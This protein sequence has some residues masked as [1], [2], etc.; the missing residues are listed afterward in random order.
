MGKDTTYENE[1]F[2]LVSG[3]CVVDKKTDEYLGSVRN[4]GIEWR[5]PSPQTKL[6]VSAF[7]GECAMNGITFPTQ[8]QTENQ[9]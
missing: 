9:A 3:C 4:G 5:Q 8:K 1:N 7:I 6:A 2:I